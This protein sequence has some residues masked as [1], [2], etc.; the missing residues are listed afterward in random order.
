M[1]RRV[2]TI[3]ASE[4][5]PWAQCMGVGFLHSV[6]DGLAEYLLG[7]VDLDRTWGAF[8]GTRVVGTLRS[9]A[10]PFTVP[11]PSEVHAAALTNVTVAPTH[12]RQGLLTEMITADLRATAER[13]EPVGILIAS[14][15]PIYGRFGY[16]PAIEGASYSVDLASTQFR[17]HGG[18]SVELVDLVTLRQ[19]APGLYEHFRSAQPG[20]IERNR[21]WWDRSLHQ[22]EVPGAKAPEGYQA[23]YRSPAGVPEGYVR[24]GAKQGWDA[25]RQSGELTV[26]EL[27]ATTPAAYDRLWRYCCEVDLITTV[28]AGDRPVDEAL[29]WL[30]TDGRAVRQTGRYDFLWV[31]VLDVIGALSA[32]RYGVDGRLVIEVVDTLG[33]A[34][35]RF[36]LEG[37]PAG[38][39]VRA[40]RADGGPF[41]A[42]GGLGLAV[43]RRCLRP[44]PARHRPRRRAP[45]RGDRSGRRH[46]PDIPVSVVLHLVLTSGARTIGLASW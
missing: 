36:A 27:V 21:R 11:G 19:E 29:G 23:L 44:C 7:D 5:R 16:G 17:R 15:Y 32:R 41:D 30:L 20:S 10:T 38:S 9:F 34:E 13:Q 12:R 3:E 22:V 26:H 40:D 31:R 25:M 18:G 35:G 24:Y 39:E 14:E 4:I 46:V 6:A 33:F 37:G 43:C 8:D 2:R 1:D 28:R 45:A 42:G